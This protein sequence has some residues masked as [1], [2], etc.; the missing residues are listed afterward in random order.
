MADRSVADAATRE[1]TIVDNTLTTDKL[2]S[3]CR[4][5]TIVHNGEAYKLRITG[6]GR[7]LLNK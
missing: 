2:F 6:N 3:E 1:L 5:L 4:E 7:L